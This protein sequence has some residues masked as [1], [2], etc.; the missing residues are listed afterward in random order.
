MILLEFQKYHGECVGILQKVR[1]DG[2]AGSHL[3][4]I[5]GLRRL[6][7]VKYAE[8]C[9]MDTDKAINN[10]FRAVPEAWMTDESR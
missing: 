3:L 1:S 6:G 5:R 7:T 10:K 9:L 2:G 8:I 4:L